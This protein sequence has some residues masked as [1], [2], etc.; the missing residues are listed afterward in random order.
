M[1]EPARRASVD[2]RGEP[3][4]IFVPLP[5]GVT[6]VAAPSLRRVFDRDESHERRP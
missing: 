1:S 6:R 5:A 4:L 2:D 3:A